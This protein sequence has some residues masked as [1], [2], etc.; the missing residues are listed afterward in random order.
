VRIAPLRARRVLVVA[1]HPDDE[2]IAAWGLMRRLLRAGARVEVLVATDGGASHPESRTW[3]RPR[4]VAERR[5]ETRRALRAL[6]IAP[7]RIGFLDLPDGSLLD[8]PDL[9]RAPLSRAVRRRRSPQ[10]IVG[11]MPDDAHGDHRAVAHALAGSPRR[12]E[13][14][15]G[16]RVWPEGAARSLGGLVVP[17]GY[18]IAA[19]RRAV[20]SYRT[21]S[22]RITDAVAG[23]AMTH[24]HL[25]AFAAPAERFAVLA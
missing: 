9:V 25:R 17:L 16:Y 23:F 12:G 15:L 3:P 1:P 18:S 20:R 11:P 21:Q 2:V 24:R 19:K 10:L 13:R 5:R 6:G 7:D 8:S 4:L 14:R 22:G